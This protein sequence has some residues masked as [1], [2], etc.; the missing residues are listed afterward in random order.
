MRFNVTMYLERRKDK[1]GNI[2]TK[3]VPIFADV[4][5]SGTRMFYFTGFR[6]DSNKFN[7]EKEQAKK[8]AFGK[9]GSRTVQYNEINN[10]LKAIRASL[11]LYFQTNRKANKEEIKGLLD[12]VCKKE[13]KDTKDAAD[14][15]TGF[16]PMFSKY[17]Q[18]EVSLSS[19]NNVKTAFNYWKKYER[20]KGVV[21]TFD[22]ITVETLRDF[23]MFLKRGSI[24][25]SGRVSKKAAGIVKSINT[26]HRI[27]KTTRAFWNYSKKE[28]GRMGIVIGYPFGDGYELPGELYG[29]P[30]YISKEER[31]MLFNAQLPNERLERVRDIFVFQCLVGARI[32]DLITFTKSNIQGNTLT[33]IPRKTKEGH[34]VTVHVPLHPMAKEIL[35]RYDIPDGKI[36]PFLSKQ[37]YNDYIKELFRVTGLTRMV[38]RLNPRT[39]QEEQVR[40][41]DIA[42]S[43]M[44]RRTFI[45]NL[46]GKVDN[47]I[48]VSMSGHAK[49]SKA[50]TRYYDVSQDL[51]EK[52]INNL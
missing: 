18:N 11:E 13:K 2:R 31:N 10:R 7:L 45:G 36:L 28:L 33:Y 24:K 6:I 29:N 12:R 37:K 17:I 22:T 25:T 30:I 48:I 9:E 52:A 32:G 21:L 5:F 3:N 40:I 41:C 38:T 39:H 8:N 23:E 51:Q 44:A 27:M 20:E 43:H 14:D 35:S 15:S 34:P 47:G 1:S 19:R 42:T 16:F 26:I 4:K 49:N 46:Y 50:F